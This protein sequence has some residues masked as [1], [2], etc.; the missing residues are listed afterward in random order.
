MIFRQEESIKPLGILDLHYRARM[1]AGILSLHFQ[2]H[3]RQ[4]RNTM[5]ESST[6]QARR[7]TDIAASGA[8]N[9]TAAS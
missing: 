4:W 7:T 9:V 2:Y 1:Q 5:H 6:G 8:C 3:A